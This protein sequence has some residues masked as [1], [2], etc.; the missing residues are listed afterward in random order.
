MPEIHGVDAMLTFLQAHFAAFPDWHERI[1]LMIA[2]DDKVAYITTGAGTHTGPMGDVP[3][4]GKK[5]E[6]VNYITQRI[7]DGRIAETWVG[8]DNLAVLVQLGLFPPPGGD[9]E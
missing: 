5:V 6:V 9:G 3:P 7:H 1:E 8:W 2:N 4:T